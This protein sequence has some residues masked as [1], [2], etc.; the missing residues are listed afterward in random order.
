MTMLIYMFQ[1]IQRLADSW[2]NIFGSTAISSIQSFCDSQ[3]VLRDSDSERQ[4]FARYY[5][6][7]L[8]FLYRESNGVD[9]KAVR[10]FHWLPDTHLIY[11]LEL[12]G[13]LPQP[14]CPSDIC[15]PPLGHRRLAE[16]FWPPWS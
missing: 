4:A 8:R 16:G 10:N 13:A 12:E 7:G 2:R 5:L 6:K 11:C 14:F 15:Y 9:D 3:E 1:T